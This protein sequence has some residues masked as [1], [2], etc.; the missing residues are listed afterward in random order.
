M[1]N[2][3]QEQWIDRFG[4][5]I[6]V[7]VSIGVGGLFD[8]WGNNLKRAP[9][10]VRRNGLEWVQLLLQQPH[11]WRR[12]LVGNPKFLFRMVAHL[13]REHQLTWKS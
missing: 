6:H 8:H 11:K 1:G 10:W 3:L 4:H 9:V 7:P 5:R 13:P 2:P 12:Y